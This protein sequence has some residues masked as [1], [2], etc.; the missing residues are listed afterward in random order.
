VTE[1]VP[2]P[3]KTAVWTT[4]ARRPAV[5]EEP[6]HPWP[7]GVSYQNQTWWPEG[8]LT[9]VVVRLHEEALIGVVGVLDFLSFGVDE[10]G[11]FSDG[12]PGIGI[13]AV[14]RVSGGDKLTVGVIGERASLHG[15]PVSH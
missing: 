13:C 12:V 5:L 10:G 8:V 2:P 15:A 14:F 4:L 7:L 9:G 6:A 3:P 1:P 11:D